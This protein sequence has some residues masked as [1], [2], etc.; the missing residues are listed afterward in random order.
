MRQWKARLYK[1]IG[2]RDATILE[3]NSESLNLEALDVLEYQRLP[4]GKRTR[5]D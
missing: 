3:A 5:G 1:L 2:A 4:W